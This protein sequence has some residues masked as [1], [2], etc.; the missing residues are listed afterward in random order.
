M[1]DEEL[2]DDEDT[3]NEIAEPVEFPCRKQKQKSKKQGKKVCPERK[4]VVN[5]LKN[6]TDKFV[7]KKGGRENSWQEK[8]EIGKC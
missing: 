5:D 6:M 2:F 4:K 7:Q 8:Q 3:F 1:G